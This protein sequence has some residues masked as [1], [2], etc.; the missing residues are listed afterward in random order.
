MLTGWK[1]VLHLRAE[2][3]PRARVGPRASSLGHPAGTPV[4]N[5]CHTLPSF[6][7]W[8]RAPCS[9][10]DEGGRE[11]RPPIRAGNQRRARTRGLRAVLAAPLATIVGPPGRRHGM[12]ASWTADVGEVE[13]CSVFRRKWRARHAVRNC[14]EIRSDHSSREGARNAV[15]RP[16][17]IP[18]CVQRAW[19]REVSPESVGPFQSGRCA[20]RCRP[21]VDPQF[22]MHPGAA[23]PQDSVEDGDD[24]G[25]TWPQRR[26]LDKASLRPGRAGGAYSKG[27]SG[28]RWQ[29]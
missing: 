9:A 29:G 21:A 18:I 23:R 1:P 13:A 6:L 2:C 5:R 17:A 26:T 14:P 7:K 19:A 12:C 24:M 20:K 22:F 10:C 27:R 15:A 16:G 4:T 28:T 11:I 8:R 3:A 25:T